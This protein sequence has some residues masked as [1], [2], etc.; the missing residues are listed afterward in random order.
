MTRNNFL[1]ILA[2]SI[3]HLPQEEQNEILFDYEEHF[4][5][6]LEQGKTE[7]EIADSLGNPAIIAAQ[8][9]SPRPAALNSQFIT[10]INT[11]KKPIIYLSILT[12]VIVLF[13]GVLMIIRYFNY[14]QNI[15]YE[16]AAR[17]TVSPASSSVPSLQQETAGIPENTQNYNIGNDERT[18]E[19]FDKQID[20]S[21]KGVKTI[22]IS[23][24]IAS[25][26]FV[27]SDSE[28]IKVH[29]HGNV[30]V[31]QGNVPD[32]FSAIN[33]D[34]LS[35][36]TKSS[37][38]NINIDS[39][40][41]VMDVYLPSAYT[42]SIKVSTQSGGIA[43]NGYKLES[44]ACDTLSG[45]VEA[46]AISAEKFTV[47]TLSGSIRLNSV[48]SRLD[49]KSVS[50]KIDIECKELLNDINANSS[51]GNIKLMLPEKAGFSVNANSTSGII[52]NSF[53]IEQKNELV[54]SSLVGTVG[55]GG[56]H[57][58]ISTV[59]GDINILKNV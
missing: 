4:R 48:V 9:V 20:S 28:D 14:D 13:I 40:D 22:S 43:I 26:K 29:L 30:T 3:K 27:K 59:S 6:G 54:N 34:T 36:T 23:Y 31:S 7:E 2:Q 42:G 55:K 56:K 17:A 58:S 35:I 12:G 41:F 5:I 53:N 38:E 15:K 51:S 50:G 25:V 16:T 24:P 44:F 49:L 8:Y 32:I 45:D 47:Q 1:N 37:F 21:L 19:Y 52:K 39:R 10:G 11:G 57:I 46:E 33:G 18:F